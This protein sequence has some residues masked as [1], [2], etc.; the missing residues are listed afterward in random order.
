MD[1]WK[2][3]LAFFGSKKG[4]KQP[5]LNLLE[6]SQIVQLVLGKQVSMNKVHLDNFQCLFTSDKFPC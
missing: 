2:L 6:I 5:K 3:F 4:K 1:C